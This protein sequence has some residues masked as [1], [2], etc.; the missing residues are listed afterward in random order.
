MRTKFT[1]THKGTIYG[2]TYKGVLEVN[3]RGFGQCLAALGRALPDDTLKNLV[4]ITAEYQRERDTKWHPVLGNEAVIKAFIEYHNPKRFAR[5]LAALGRHDDSAEERDAAW[6][7]VETQADLHSAAQ[8]DREAELDV[9][10]AFWLDT[11]DYNTREDC[12]RIAVE[13]IRK[14]TK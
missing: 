2:F 12:M 9:Q 11:S 5:T 14:A 4:N 10:F 8:L 7:K 13:A 1:Y 6:Q 3:E